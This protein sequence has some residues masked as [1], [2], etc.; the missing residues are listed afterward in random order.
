MKPGI[1]PQTKSDTSGKILGNIYILIATIFFGVNIPVVKDLIPEWLTDTDVTAIRIGGGCA[2]MWL[3]S[4]FIR[5]EKIERNDWKSII[6]GGMLGLF[7]FLWLFNMSLRYADPIDVSIIMTL[8]PVFVIIINAVRGLGRPGWLEAAGVVTAFAGAIL[9]ILVGHSGAHGHDEILGDIL[10]LVSSLCYAFYLVVIEKP[11][12]KYKPVS[13]LR[14]I[15]LAALVPALVLIPGLFHAPLFHTSQPWPW[16]E[17][18]FVVVC[19]TFLAYFLV[20]PA[21]RLIGSEIV[22]IYQYLVP[23]V[24]CIASVMMHIAHLRSIQII[25]MIVIIA[26]ML[27]TTKAHSRRIGRNPAPK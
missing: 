7:S 17:I 22:S 14:W 12:K 1:L 24:A 4:V 10:A 23:V 5:T 11:S 20:S 6:I 25:A 2:L 13:L 27:I 8:P 9:V 16:I 18:A 3:A 15:F 21:T 26:G 19:P